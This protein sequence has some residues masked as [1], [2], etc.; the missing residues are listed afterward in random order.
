MPIDAYINSTDAHLKLLRRLN[1]TGIQLIT[2]GVL[3]NKRTSFLIGTG[4]AQELLKISTCLHPWHA[5][6]RSASLQ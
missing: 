6:D 3:S 1:F 2:G 5:L 4:V